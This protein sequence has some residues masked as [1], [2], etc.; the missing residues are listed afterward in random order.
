ML[1]SPTL[2][3]T[4]HA[5]SGQL[6]EVVPVCCLVFP[7]TVTERVLL[8]SQLSIS[9]MQFPLISAQ[10]SKSELNSGVLVH[11]AVRNQSAA[12]FHIWASLSLCCA[13]VRTYN[14]RGAI[15]Y[16]CIAGCLRSSGM[17]GSSLIPHHHTCH[18]PKRRTKNTKDHAVL[19]SDYRQPK[20]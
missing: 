14:P 20:S 5:Q 6:F 3:V 11:I 16:A 17:K 7:Y 4:S 10:L 18:G 1:H 9:E 2:T 15:L 13:P 12:P 8:V 19:E